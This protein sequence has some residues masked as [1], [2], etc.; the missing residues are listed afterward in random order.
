MAISVVRI[1]DKSCAFSDKSGWQYKIADI[2]YR[3]KRLFIHVYV[4]MFVEFYWCK[5]CVAN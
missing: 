4:Y 5:Y 3:G 1:R 2:G